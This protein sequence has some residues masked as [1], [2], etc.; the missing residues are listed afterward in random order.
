MPI[1]FSRVF[2]GELG[3]RTPEP[4]LGVNGISILLDYPA[5]VIDVVYIIGLVYI[6]SSF[7]SFIRSVF[8][9]FEK[10]EYDAASRLLERTLTL[11]VLGLLVTNGSVLIQIVR[12]MLAVQIHTCP[13]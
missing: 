13:R 3:I 9:A 8:R 12:A 2:Q 5:P 4:R 7:T 1:G 10:M 11:G 6:L